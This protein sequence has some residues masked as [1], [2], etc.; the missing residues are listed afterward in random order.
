LVKRIT[1]ADVALEA[2]VPQQTVSRAINN[3]GEISLDTRAFPSIPARH[4][5]WRRACCRWL[6]GLVGQ[7]IIELDEAAEMAYDLAYRLPLE[8]YKLRRNHD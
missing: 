4:D 8:A 7:A 2:G 3:K 5:V 6:A 1:I